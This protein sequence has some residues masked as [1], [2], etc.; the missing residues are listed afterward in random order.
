[1]GLV[2][3]GWATQR[4]DIRILDQTQSDACS[5]L[6]QRDIYGHNM[7]FILPLY[8]GHLSSKG[9]AMNADNF[10]NELLDAL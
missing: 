10:A 2:G 7:I 1:M 3:I 8:P 5:L 4:Q 6:W 9:M